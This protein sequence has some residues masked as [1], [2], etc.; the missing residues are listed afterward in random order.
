MKDFEFHRKYANLPLEERDTNIF[1]EN[2]YLTPNKIYKGIKDIDDRTRVDLIRK[3][4]LLKAFEKYH[5][6]KTN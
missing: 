2:E 3:D 4:R 5:N 6:D 1:F